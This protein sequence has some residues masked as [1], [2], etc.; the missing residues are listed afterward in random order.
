MGKSS[1]RSETVRITITEEM[2]Q[3]FEKIFGKQSQLSP[4]LPMIFYKYLR[5][6]WGYENNPIHRKQKCVYQQPIQV[7]NSYDCHV[8]LDRQVRK[9][10][11]MFYTESLLGYDEN[12]EECFRCISEVIARFT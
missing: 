9:G 7:G 11:H 10:E 4:T 3:D 6:P 12:G 8:V 5:V 1:I 2:V